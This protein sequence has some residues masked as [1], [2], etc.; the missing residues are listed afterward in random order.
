M[1][2]ISFQEI[3]Y[4]TKNFQIFTKHICRRGFDNFF[5]ILVKVHGQTYRLNFNPI[6]QTIHVKILHLISPEQM[7]FNKSM[8]I[9]K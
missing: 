3:H 7:L 9:S 4:H 6:L 2:L 5:K 8:Q 1:I